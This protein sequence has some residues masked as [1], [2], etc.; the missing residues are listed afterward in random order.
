MRR[1]GRVIMVLGVVLGA[2]TAI[3]LFIVL[4]TRPSSAPAPTKTVSVVIAQ[5]N[6]AMHAPIP[7]SALTLYEWPDDIQL[8]KDTYTD[9]V[10]LTNKLTT[11]PIAIGQVIV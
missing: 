11:T 1:G 10:S 9:I 6:I 2:I 4:N 5:Q 8:P 3:A 7:A